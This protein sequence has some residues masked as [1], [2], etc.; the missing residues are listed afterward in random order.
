MEGSYSTTELGAH[1]QST[2]NNAAKYR[3]GMTVQC[4]RIAMKVKYVSETWVHVPNTHPRWSDVA[5][6]DEEWTSLL[7][8][9]TEDLSE[10]DCYLS[11]NNN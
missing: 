2:R 6:M 1:I 9:I 5:I 4:D 7:H 10:M 3:F 8:I 11:A